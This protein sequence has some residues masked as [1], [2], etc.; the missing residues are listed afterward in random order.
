MGERTVEACG[1]VTFVDLKNNFKA[2]II[3][4]TYKKSGFWTTTE[5]G[6]R[7]EYI[8]MIYKCPPIEDPEAIIKTIYDK[9]KKDL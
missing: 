7:D 8:G 9:H 4:S 1:D 3:F 6:K 5:S 2:V